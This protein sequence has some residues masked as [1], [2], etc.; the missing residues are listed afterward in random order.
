MEQER[1]A[2]E[3]EE[4]EKQE[5][6]AKIKEQFGDG[7]E[8]WEMDKQ[9]MSDQVVKKP[10]SPEKPLADTEGGKGKAK[11]KADGSEKKDAAE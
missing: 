9:E 7:G 3:K 4:Q 1:I 10:V 5:K 6:A 8:Q 2:R 11:A